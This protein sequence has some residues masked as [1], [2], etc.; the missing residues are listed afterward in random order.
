[1]TGIDSGPPEGASPEYL[2]AWR[3]LEY[4]EPH[5]IPEAERARN[6]VRP[7]GGWRAPLRAGAADAA[8]G[9]GADAAAAGEMVR[10]AASWRGWALAL[11][12]LGQGA[13]L[14][15][16]FALFVYLVLSR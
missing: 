5:E 10:G 14:A 8:A 7:P 12:Q 16:A 11:R 13:L 9:A 2:D 4:R 1:M 6:P 3:R 15:G